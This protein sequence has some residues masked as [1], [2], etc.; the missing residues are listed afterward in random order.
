M[1]GTKA[2]FDAMMLEAAEI[3]SLTMRRGCPI[4]S[5]DKCIMHQL[6]CSTYPRGCCWG[7]KETLKPAW[8]LFLD[9]DGVEF[10]G[11]IGSL[12][13]IEMDIIHKEESL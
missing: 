6:L 7:R 9:D 13:G 12:R 10:N 2:A 1:G 5:V 3:A 11:W 8:L 4:L